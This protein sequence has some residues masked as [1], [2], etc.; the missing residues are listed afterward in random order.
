[1]LRPEHPW[2]GSDAPLAPSVRSVAYGKVNQ[3]RDPAIFEED[4]RTYLLYA[5]AGESGI[6]IAELTFV[7]PG[8]TLP[9]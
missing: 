9:M 1:V 6:A 3:L 5:V 2:E 8:L 7:D 4:G